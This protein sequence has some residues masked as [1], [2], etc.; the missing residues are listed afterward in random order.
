MVHRAGLSTRTQRTPDE[1]SG[2]THVAAGPKERARPPSKVITASGADQEAPAR[3]NQG[4]SYLSTTDRNSSTSR[5]AS[6]SRHEETPHATTPRPALSKQ[7][8]KNSGA[9]EQED[10]TR[11]T[12][13][14]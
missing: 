6:M 5:S 13:R 2:A 9:E 12:R 8:E 14:T 1:S 11:S 4:P 7:V 10:G 3:L